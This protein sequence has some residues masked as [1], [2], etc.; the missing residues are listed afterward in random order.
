MSFLDRKIEIPDALSVVVGDDSLSVELRD[1]R[2]I[3]VPLLWY[4]RLEN[5]SKAERDNWQL[6]G[7]GEGIH[8]P[9]LDEDISIAGL[10]AGDASKES[11]AS[12]TRW[13]ENRNK[14]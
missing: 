2:A 5:G 9:D 3:T 6:I 4:P 1:G 14:P 13:L 11:S 7:C 8:W 12:F 10:I